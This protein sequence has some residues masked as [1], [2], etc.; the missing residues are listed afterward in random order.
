[1]ETDR[2]CEYCGDDIEDDDLDVIR[3][4]EYEWHD[5]TCYR[6]WLDDPGADLTDLRR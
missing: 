2:V 4:G 3:E 6:S 1:M 5:Q